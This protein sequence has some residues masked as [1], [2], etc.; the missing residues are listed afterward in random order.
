[1]MYGAL[2]FYVLAFSTNLPISFQR[3]NLTI[4]KNDAVNKLEIA[5]FSQTK[6]IRIE[7]S[8]TEI[9]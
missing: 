4:G 1:M 5:N 8:S 9:A 6:S 7:T 2:Q 3:I